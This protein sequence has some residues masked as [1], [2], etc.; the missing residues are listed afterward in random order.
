MLEIKLFAF[1][2][3]SWRMSAVPISGAKVDIFLIS[4]ISRRSFDCRLCSKVFSGV[5]ICSK[6]FR[7]VQN[8]PK[9]PAT[10]FGV[11]GCR[12][13][14]N[15]VSKLAKI[16]SKLTKS[17]IFGCKKDKNDS[18]LPDY[19]QAWA[20]KDE[21]FVDLTWQYMEFLTSVEHS[22]YGKGM[23]KI[24]DGLTYDKYCCRS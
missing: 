24:Y 22:I 2:L 3:I 20:G 17:S 9:G 13:S 1:F 6:T 14:V 23:D 10:E 19:A 18:D 21:R 5:S 8:T 11:G 16:V 4:H 7:F 12:I 15:G